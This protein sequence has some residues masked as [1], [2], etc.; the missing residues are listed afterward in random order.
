MSHTIYA[1]AKCGSTDLWRDAAVSINDPSNVAEHDATNCSHCGYDGT[2]YLSVQV[3]DRVVV[4]DFTDASYVL[5]PEWRAKAE[6]C[7][8]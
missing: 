4:D 2:H 3:E 5:L 7:Y 8:L 6:E 1:C